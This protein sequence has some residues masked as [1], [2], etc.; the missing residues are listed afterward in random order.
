LSFFKAFA[1]SLLGKADIS[2]IVENLRKDELNERRHQI[3]FEDDILKVL[4]TYT[5]GSMRRR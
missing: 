1:K 5:R 2:L 3:P 4:I